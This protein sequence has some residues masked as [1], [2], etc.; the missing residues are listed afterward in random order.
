MSHSN[1]YL[2]DD[3]QLEA[4]TRENL[5]T[6]REG[7]AD[8]KPPK[9]LTQPSS[10]LLC[11]DYV[12]AALLVAVALFIMGCAIGCQHERNACGKNW[13]EYDNQRR[14]LDVYQCECEAQ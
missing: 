6:I 12:I 2:T 3:E 7:N 13:R 8:A 11:V 5:K 14:A 10:G 1:D 9:E 4:L